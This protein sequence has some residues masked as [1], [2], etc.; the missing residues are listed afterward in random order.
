MKK[1]LS[2]LCFCVAMAGCGGSYRQSAP[3]SSPE[4]LFRLHCSGC[5]GNGNG[6]GH[7]AGTLKV[8]PRNLKFREWQQSVS[9]RHITDVI[10]NG[11][12]PYKLSEEM[13]GFRDK[14]TESQIHQLTQYIRRIGR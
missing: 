3:G 1:A 2:L 12:K 9:D 8:R 6:D 14:L 11:G 5:H 7:I 4:E 13:P 10:T